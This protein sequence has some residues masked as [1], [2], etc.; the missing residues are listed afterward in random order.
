MERML[1]ASALRDRASFD[2]IASY[3]TLKKY[4]RPFQIV[5][6]FIKQYYLR[7]TEAQHVL[8]EL[9]I[10]FITETTR[11]EK[12]VKEFSDLINEAWAIDVSNA[13]VKQVILESKKGELADELATALV[14][15]TDYSEVLEKFVDI[16]TLDEYNDK[17]VEVYDASNFLDAMVNTAQR[18]DLLTVF[19]RSINDRLDGGVTGGDH[20]LVYARPETGKTALCISIAAGFAR[21]GA[22]GIYFTNEDRPQ[23]VLY[24]IVSNL[25]GWTRHQIDEDVHTAFAL[26]ME[27]G[28][29][30]IRVLSFAPGNPS[31]IEAAI[32]KYNPRWCV[33]DQLRNIEMRSDNR[34]V[35]L[36]MAANFGRKIA[37]M[38]NMIVVSVAQAGDSADGK[39][40]L[41][42]GDVDW[43]NTGI[44]AQMDLMIGM[45]VT[46]A[47]EQ[48]GLRM[49]SLPKNKIGG[50]HSHFMVRINQFLSRVMT[51]E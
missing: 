37:K 50:D 12:H 31:Q 36:E 19:P 47:L 5:W 8:P 35:Q 23:R 7:D 51:I 3:I 18:A 11:N 16:A 29:R 46:P 20:I 42:M 9:L 25:I 14:N 41:T 48:Q 39:E 28:L 30:H 15:R 2:L 44:P 21:Q 1:L 22:D 17:G 24:R 45:G 6:D 13:N 40:I 34:A 43:S 27:A 49:I 10:A 26:A 33:I 32:E 38:Y 4:S